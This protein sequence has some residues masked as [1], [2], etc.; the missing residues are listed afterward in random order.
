MAIQVPTGLSITTTLYS[1]EWTV[2]T[3]TNAIIS[4]LLPFPS[5]EELDLRNS[6]SFSSLIISHNDYEE[7]E[8][9]TIELLT[10]K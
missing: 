10:A 9:K 2:N 8:R 5:T 3:D 6:N 7:V 4:F 1:Q